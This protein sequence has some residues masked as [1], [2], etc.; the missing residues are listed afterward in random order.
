MPARIITEAGPAA[1]TVRPIEQDV[2]LVGR[3][4]ACASRPTALAAGRAVR[5]EYD[6]RRYRVYNKLAGP[7]RLESQTVPPRGAC[8]WRHGERL[9]LGGGVVLRLDI[10]GDPAPAREAP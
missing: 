4:G 9:S 10:D 5:V 2:T 8:E 7:I 6:D 1:G 3:D